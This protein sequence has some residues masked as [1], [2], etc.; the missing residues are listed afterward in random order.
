MHRFNGLSIF[1]L[2][3]GLAALAGCRTVPTAA[4]ATQTTCVANTTTAEV[5]RAARTVLSRMSFA[6]EK[7]DPKAGLVRTEPLAGAQFFELWRS[8]NTRFADAVASNIHSIRK[9]VELHVSPDEGQLRLDCTV[10][11]ERLSL[12]GQDIASV[13]Q[14][15]RM[16]SRSLPD[17][18][19]F[20]LTPAQR[21][22]MTWIEM[23]NDEPLAAEIVRRIQKQITRQ[24]EEEVT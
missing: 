10:R 2:S 21:A 12:P 8:D 24:P 18:Q 7:A 9:S 22:Q 15:Y 3:A 11:V 19:T 6:I 5:V 16:H 13:S 23:G 14:A 17:L 4:P 1:L 20:I